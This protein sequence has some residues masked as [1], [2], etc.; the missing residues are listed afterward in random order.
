MNEPV[1]KGI[2]EGCKAKSFIQCFTCMYM[3]E[4]HCCEENMAAV[5]TPIELGA[6]EEVTV[7]GR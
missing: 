5:A 2:C 1:K 6:P 3:L 7:D 4:G